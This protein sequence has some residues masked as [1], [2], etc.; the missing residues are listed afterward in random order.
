MSDKREKIKEAIALLLEAVN[1]L[2]AEK[3]D[4]L[5]LKEASGRYGFSKQHLLRLAKSGVIKLHR[6]S[7]RKLYVSEA[8]LE[9]VI[10]R[11]E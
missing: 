9:A 7:P 8:E 1:E 2:P 3:K 11:N 6:L 10:K 4:L 5:T